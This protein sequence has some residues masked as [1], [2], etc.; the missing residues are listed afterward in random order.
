MDAVW[1]SQGE[2]PVVDNAD[3]FFLIEEFRRN[4]DRM[5]FVHLLVFNWT[6]RVYKEFLREWARFRKHVT[7]PLYA[8]A[9]PTDVARWEKFVSRMGFTPLM[10]VICENGAKRRL[11]VHIKNQEEKPHEP[12]V[13]NHKQQSDARVHH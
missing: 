2:T 13:L 5:V 6:L 10:P 7:C 1:V 8:V 3:Y 4:E 11:F 12:H 9:G